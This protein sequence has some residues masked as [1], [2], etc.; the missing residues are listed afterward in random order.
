M[1]ARAYENKTEWL[2]PA[3]L[4]LLSIVPVIAGTAR[5]AELSGGAEITPENARFFA[6]PWPVLLHIFSFIPYSILGAFQ[7]APGL[8]RRRPNWHR[9][10]GRLLIPAGLVAALS[11]LWMTLFYPWPEGDGELLYGIRLIVGSAMVLSIVFGVAA[12]R[13]RDIAQHRAWMIRAYAIGMGAGTQ[14]FTHLPWFILFGQP[15]EFPR[16]LLMG[17]G[18]A[19]N[20]IIA[21]WIIHRRLSHPTR[22]SPAAVS[23]PL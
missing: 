2:V 18:W 20:I 21:E 19:I 16:A 22:T 5:L 13:R 12:I 14:A 15:D 17:A 6:S 10:T 1:K 4:I 3:G 11:G 8:R 7:F 9:T 23:H